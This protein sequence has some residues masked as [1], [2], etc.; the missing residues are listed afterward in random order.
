MPKVR[1]E[2]ARFCGIN[3]RPRTFSLF[4]RHCNN[5]IFQK[6]L[7]KQEDMSHRMYIMLNLFHFVL[8]LVYV[9]DKWFESEPLKACLA[10]DSIIGATVS[11]STPGSA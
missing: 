9:L 1:K 3:Y 11:P 6:K 5:R 4:V 2:Q 10:M 7:S 8:L